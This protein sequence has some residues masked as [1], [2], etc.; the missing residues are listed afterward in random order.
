MHYSCIRNFVSNTWEISNFE[1]FALFQ[2]V[3]RVGFFLW[4]S[5]SSSTLSSSLGCGNSEGAAVDGGGSGGGGAISTGVAA[6][7]GN[8]SIKWHQDAPSTTSSNVGAESEL[9]PVPPS[10]EMGGGATTVAAEKCTMEEWERVLSESVTASP[11]QE[12]S[13]L[14]WIMGMWMTL[15]WLT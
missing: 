4:Q 5:P 2:L 13:I 10:F 7:S 15:L 3:Q 1:S 8:S 6:V 14:R 9:H 12:Q 11:S